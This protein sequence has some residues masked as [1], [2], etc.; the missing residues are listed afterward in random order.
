MKR[1]FVVPILLLSLLV[2]NPAFSADFQ[3]GLDAYD[4]EDYETALNELTPLAEQ[5][6]VRAQFFLGF[7]YNYGKGVPQ[8]YKTAVKWYMLAANNGDADAQH[9]L[10]WMYDSGQGIAQNF[11]FAAKWYVRAAEQG[12]KKAQFNLASMYN[13][14]NGVPQDFVLAYMWWSVSASL[15]DEIAP[16]DRDIVVKKLSPTELKTAQL[17]ARECIKKN[18]RAPRIMPYFG[19]VKVNWV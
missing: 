5:G 12:H 4:K 11:K 1:L 15:G 14:G 2:G 9:S 13:R 18:Y 6:N 7:M 17:L 10:G 19:E 16:F 3:K 8:D